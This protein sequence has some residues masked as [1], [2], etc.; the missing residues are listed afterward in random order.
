MEC[1]RRGRSL[2]ET[3]KK[4]ESWVEEGSDEEG[5][6]SRDELEPECG[7]SSCTDAGLSGD[8]Q[9]SDEGE[10]SCSSATCVS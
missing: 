5:S 10:E 4:I 3:E 7:V 2:K 6:L 8:L 1:G 9:G